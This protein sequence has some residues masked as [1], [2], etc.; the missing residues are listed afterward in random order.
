MTI[1]VMLILRGIAGTFGGKN[2]P[3][4][5]LD[6]ESATAYARLRGY[7]PR[8]LDVS[9]EAA[10][11]S[12]Q[13]KIALAE[14]LSDRDIE[15]IYGFSGGAYNLAH[16][17]NDLTPDEKEQLNLVIALGAPGNPASCYQGPWE[18]VYR[19]DP[20]SGHMDG[21]RVLLAEL[22]KEKPAMMAMPLRYL[23][24]VEDELAGVEGEIIEVGY[25]GPRPKAGGA[26]RYANLLDQT[27]TAKYGPYL[28]GTD[29][30]AE[31][32]ERVVDP[33]GVG[34]TKLLLDQ[35]TSAKTAGFD[36]IEWD[37]P[38][39]Y[40]QA[41]V[42]SAVDFATDHGL[43]VL[44]KNPLICDWDAVPYVKRPAVV[45][46]V[47]EEDDDA[48]P[49]VY[50]DLRKA[51]GKPELPVWF[52][53]FK[54]GKDDGTAWAQAT[55]KEAA[56]Y[57][58]MSVTMSPDGEYTSSV[59]VT[60]RATTPPI[61]AATDCFPVCVQLVLVHEGGNDDDPRDPGGR[62]SRGIIQHPEYD[63]WR[64][65]HPGLPADVWQAP[66]ATVLAIYRAKYWNVCRC[67]DLPM[68]V[69]Y[70]V[71]DYGINSGVSRAI[72]LLQTQLGTTVD[73]AIGPLTVAAA[74]STDPVAFINKYQD[75]RL[76][77][78]HG[79]GTWS[80]FGKGWGTRVADVRRDA[81]NMAQATASPPD[82]PPAPIYDTH[83]VQASL[84][85]L[86]ASPP[87]VEDGKMGP[88][89]RAAIKDFQSAHGLKPD[90]VAGPLTRAE[91]VQ[92]LKTQGASLPPIIEP[93]KPPATDTELHDLGHRIKRTM[94]KL[95]PD[96]WFPDQNV[97]SVEGMD[98]SGAVNK[99]RHNAFDDVKMV[100]DGDGKIICG[101]FEGTTA[102]GVFWTTHPM[103]AGG[104]FII[105]LGPQAV[106]TPGPYHDRTVWRQ[107]EDSHIMGTRDPHCT[108]K[109]QGPPVKYG[110]IGIHHHFGYDLPRDNISNAAAGCQVIR[111]ETDQ[112]KFMEATMNN[113]RYLA[114]KKNYRLLATVLEAKDVLP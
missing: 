51:A 78:L 106:W 42:L 28:V 60:A 32:N 113:R 62:T 44:A 82:Q 92:Q 36:T 53:A 97:V 37:N 1:P 63:S 16:V 59:D 100:L 23:I 61:A 56:K 74:N 34:W 4:G 6:E 15:A 69:D 12:K 95:Y 81:L 21:P 70:C 65:D 67:D 111:L 13:H 14:V 108:Y 85:Q 57:S 50:D 101:P 104:A 90:G 11:G 103:A 71:F 27:N 109:R 3:R 33:K 96:A 107:A 40:T 64:A 31:Y 41:A 54:D 8:V 110:A 58:N 87:L 66:Q 102:P 114:D 88:A 77:F 47:V 25:D 43:K 30:A 19:T 86:G 17:L 93:P 39:S 24:E 22:Q 73:G 7:E 98:P 46:I 75:A 5:A 84:N 94:L 29:T 99:N 26:V 9:G 10:V 45:G 52:V 79:L 105:A 89:T 18:T 55:A 35:C 76:S 20:P 38:D 48:T 112:K 72:K 49:A 91:I 83:W 80:V 68:G 2:Y